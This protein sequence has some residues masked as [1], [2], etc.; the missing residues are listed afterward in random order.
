MTL[1]HLLLG[2]RF[3]TLISLFSVAYLFLFLPVSLILYSVTPQKLRRYA[4]L[5]ISYMFYWLIS[6]ELI[7]YLLVST[8]GIHYFGLWLDRVHAQRAEALAA[9]PREE[10][11][12]LRA[13]WQKKLRR[14]LALA[15]LVHLGALLVVKYS[16]FFTWNI[17]TLFQAIHVP[18]SMR[19]PRY[20]Q[21]L[22]I[23][24]FTMQALA[25]ILDVY[26]GT[27]KAD[28][29]LGRLALFMAFFPQI[30]E[31]PI[32][33][34]QDTAE[35]LWNA[36][37]I[38][39]K[40]LK[41]GLQRIAFGM[42]KKVVVADRLNQLIEAVF[43]APQDFSGAAIALT[44]VCYTIQL[45]MDFSGSMDAVCGTAQIFGVTMPENFQ[46]P[47][48]SRTISEFW[49]RWH[50]TLGTWFRDYLFYPISVSGPM[51]SLTL[52]ARRKLGNHYGPLLAG[53]AALLCVWFCNGLWHGAGWNYIVF[54]LYHFVLIY[55]GSVIAPVARGMNAKLKIDANALPYRV[56]QIL[57]T[58]LL[59]VVGEV[60]FR[61]DQVGKAF[62]MLRRIFTDFNGVTLF[63]GTLKW[64]RVDAMEC[65]IVCA[66][67]LI[68]FVVGLLK[69]RGHNLREA[70]DR[71]NIVVRWAVLYA[72]LMYIVIFG[73][74]G[75]GYVPVDPMYANF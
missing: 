73:A 3:A 60:F 46:R 66:T 39:F 58:A 24:F 19:M 38:E 10:K 7:A 37:G 56:F 16:A 17:N 34:Y 8:L 42:V 23:S 62:F 48:F 59:V 64:L 61:A 13:A 26:R 27:R 67:L 51:K 68:V 75:V 15:V 74:Y 69:E 20:A 65:L 41:F 22:G 18:L 14:V 4:L 5:L 43:K 71:R 70:I 49:Q 53:G 36:R 35:A 6:G 1:S 30:V 32:C 25:Y 72:L 55:L 63:D 33:R 44:A 45:Y 50:I 2:G 47:F 52:S 31:G 12:A 9:A 54:G 28:D 57:R 21:P 11:K 29:N 40:N